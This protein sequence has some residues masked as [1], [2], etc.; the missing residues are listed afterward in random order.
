MNALDYQR[1]NRLRLWFIDPHLVDSSIDET[2]RTRESFISAIKS[3]AT[4]AERGLRH[5]G[6]LVFVVG[7]QLKRKCR[8]QH[9]AQTAID[10][11]TRHAPSLRLEQVIG[12]SYPRRAADTA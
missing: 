11:M 9:P 3:V 12:R 5:L 1:D 7:E 8:G 2:T 10:I 4:K 6:P